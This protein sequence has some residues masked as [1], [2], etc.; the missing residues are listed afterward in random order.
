MTVAGIYVVIVVGKYR[1][2]ETGIYFDISAPLQKGTY[3]VHY[4][5]PNIQQQSIGG[6]M[7]EYKYLQFT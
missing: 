5:T 3:D 7:E 4:R 2:V 6:L 1:R